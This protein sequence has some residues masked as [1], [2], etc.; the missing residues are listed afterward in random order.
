MHIKAF[1]RLQLIVPNITVGISVFNT[2]LDQT[3]CELNDADGKIRAWY[4]LGN[5]V[6]ELRSSSLPGRGQISALSL[7]CDMFDKGE[8]ATFLHR[9]T[10]VIE[11]NRPLPNALA[12]DLQL[13]NGAATNNLRQQAKL[14]SGPMR[15]DHIVLQSNNAQHC[16]DLFEKQLG[17]RLALDKTVAEWGGRMLF[18][19]AGKLTLE[20]IENSMIDGNRF[21]GLA[22][23]CD[24]LELQ[25]SRLR[26]NN[27]AVS[28]SRKGRKPGTRVSTVKDHA[29]GLP[30]LLIQ[31]ELLN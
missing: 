27:M 3:A 17:I 30:V 15:C 21:W 8:E 13:C 9:N 11:S 16:I 26:E 10:P 29:L 18:F 24:D 12:L 2:L 23:A 4:D 22:L 5:T 31:Q 14:T 6:L 19:R 20:V 25:I 7:H 28:D 1:D